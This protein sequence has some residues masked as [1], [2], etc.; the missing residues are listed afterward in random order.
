[1]HYMLQF[2][3]NPEERAKHNDAAQVEAYFAGW[4]AFIGTLAQSGAMVSGNGLLPPDTATT[5]RVMG[6]CQARD[7]RLADAEASLM[8]SYQ[9][10]PSSAATAFNLAGVQYRRGEYERARFYIDRVNKSGPEFIKTEGLYYFDGKP[11]F[12]MGQGQK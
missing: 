3:E 9:L 1:M 7:G 6:N 4:T 11:A 2:Y 8:R 12:Q 5:L 10:D